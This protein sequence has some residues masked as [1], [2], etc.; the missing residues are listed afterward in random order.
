MNE[1]LKLMSLPLFPLGTLALMAVGLCLVV[2]RGSA[3]R[4]GAAAMS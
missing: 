1:D 4:K 2:A 3:S